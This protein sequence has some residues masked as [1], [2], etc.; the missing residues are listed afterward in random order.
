MLLYALV[1]SL[2]IS[3]CVGPSLLAEGPAPNI[4][5]TFGQ[6]GTSITLIGNSNIGKVLSL[7]DGK[8]LA[9]GS[10]ARD[11]RTGDLILARYNSDG[12]LDPT[13]GDQ[14]LLTTQV[15]DGIIGCWKVYPCSAVLQA[16]GKILVTASAIQDQTLGEFAFIRFNP[17]GSLDST[18]GHGGRAMPY[19]D[20]NDRLY[21]I[22]QQRDGKIIAVGIPAGDFWQ[23]ILARLNSDGSLDSTFGQ[24][25][26]VVH[27]LRFDSSPRGVAVLPDGKIL[28]AGTW[29]DQYNRHDFGLVRFTPDG[30]LDTSFGENG[31]VSTDVSGDSDDVTTLSIQPDG[32]I[33]VLG[34]TCCS[35]F[36][37]SIALAR[38]SAD[39][40]LDPS[41]GTAGLAIHRFEVYTKPYD[42][43][44]QPDGKI[45]VTG[46]AMGTS[47][48][49]SRFITVRYNSNGSLDTTF[50]NGG[51]A[52]ARFGPY[53]YAA[54]VTIQPDGRILSAG[55]GQPP[56]PTLAPDGIVRGLASNCDFMLV[57][58]LP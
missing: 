40:I 7:P 28:V 25:G 11:A 3:G 50:G 23:T 54:A 41:F 10:K 32:K 1:L 58:Y 27:R 35:K 47:Y 17:D 14:G 44:L 56:P 34:A 38:Y 12:S 37:Y 48:P 4:D 43:A 18:F 36:P 24:A 2:L 46:E 19:L 45:I 5:R 21:S 31:A 39:G 57:R 29:L 13:F 8:I 51:R 15:G 49:D 20:G 52:I 55:C 6:D 26:H 22:V 33:I 9:V 53:A 42:I 16:D 30:T